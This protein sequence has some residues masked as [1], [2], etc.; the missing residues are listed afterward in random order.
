M[1]FVTNICE[2]LL[3]HEQVC[4]PRI[5]YNARLAKRTLIT[6]NQADNKARRHAC[7]GVN[8]AFRSH[9]VAT[10]ALPPLD[11]CT[12]SFLNRST[13]GVK[14]PTCIC[15]ELMCAIFVEIIAVY[16]YKG[17]GWDPHQGRM[18]YC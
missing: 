18:H 16:R 3:T 13:P 2:V 4:F 10:R 14:E 12:M 17:Q 6:K 15:S 9:L 8:S 1:I 11:L 7:D 5:H